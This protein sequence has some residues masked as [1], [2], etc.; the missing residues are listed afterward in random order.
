MADYEGPVAFVSGVHYPAVDDGFD[1]KRPLRWEDGGY[2][3][4]VKD[5]PLHN[6]VHFVNELE[7][8]VGEE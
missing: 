6:D 7:L 2:R 3:D 4:A 5:E 8:E 1:L